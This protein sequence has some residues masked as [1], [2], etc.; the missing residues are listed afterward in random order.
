MGPLAGSFLT[1][2]VSWEWVFWTMMIF[3]GVCWLSIV[4]FLPE[5]FAPVL[6]MQKAKRLRKEGNSK[7]WAPHERIDWSVSGVVKRT[8]FRPF[9][10][11]ALEPILLLITIYLAIVYGLLYG[12]FEAVPVLFADIRGFNLGLSSLPFLGVLVGTTLGAGLNVALQYKYF[13]LQK[14]SERCQYCL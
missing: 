9:Q 8:L 14:V 2:E 10:I 5:T 1:Q 6:L 7:A 3:A 4:L 11:L 13:T 12:L